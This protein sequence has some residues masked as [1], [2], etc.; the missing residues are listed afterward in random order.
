MKSIGVTCLSLASWAALALPAS[1]QPKEA[2]PGEIGFESF[3]HNKRPALSKAEGTPA[4]GT[5]PGITE[6]ILI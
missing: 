6:P 1:A 3:C 5:P 2:D 4:A